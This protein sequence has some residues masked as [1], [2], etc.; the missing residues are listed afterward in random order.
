MTSLDLLMVRP[1]LFRH[2]NSR[3][4]DIVVILLTEAPL[5]TLAWRQALARLPDCSR[6]HNVIRQALNVFRTIRSTFGSL[7][8]SIPDDLPEEPDSSEEEKEEDSDMS[9]DSDGLDK[10]KKL[11]QPEKP[12]NAETYRIG[13]RGRRL[14]RL[15][16]ACKHQAAYHFDRAAEVND[17]LRAIGWNATAMACYFAAWH[18]A[19]EWSELWDS[20]QTE[21][22]ALFKEWEVKVGR[23]AKTVQDGMME[24]A[25]AVDGFAEK[26]GIKPDLS[27]ETGRLAIDDETGKYSH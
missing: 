24:L 27:P 4:A 17:A 26:R 9:V 8:L 12:V 18:E 5:L 1:R 2:C 10:P 20:D 22:T 13:A 15:F 7:L 16:K 11:K 3:K 19:E 14:G 25:L 6:V 21:R 23:Y